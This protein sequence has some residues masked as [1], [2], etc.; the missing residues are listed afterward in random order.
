M[1]AQILELQPVET[2]RQAF[3]QL[4]WMRRA[5]ACME[6]LRRQKGMR[7]NPA[8]LAYLDAREAYLHAAMEAE[9]SGTDLPTPPVP[10]DP[11]ECRAS[12]AE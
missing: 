3:A 7:P 4:N 9:A 10:P 6:E 2:W 1:T 8:W 11:P 12:V 5:A